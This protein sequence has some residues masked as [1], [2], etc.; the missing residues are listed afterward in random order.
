[1]QLTEKQTTALQH[2]RDEKVHQRKYGY[3]A[4]RINS[5]SHPSVVGRVISLGLAKW[6]TV[7]DTDDAMIAVLTDLGREAL[8]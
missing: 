2:I 4:W 6:T 3:G 1:M 7:A 5:P 8:Q